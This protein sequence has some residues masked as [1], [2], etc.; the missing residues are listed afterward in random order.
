MLY[1]LN[2]DDIEKYEKLIQKNILEI[3][4]IENTFAQNSTS[5]EQI[6]RGT[7]TVQ[8]MSLLSQVATGDYIWVIYKD[9]LAIAKVLENTIDKDNLKIEIRTD[10]YE[11]NAQPEIEINVPTDGA[12][13]R[14]IDG[15]V[16]IETIALFND[17]KLN[18]SKNTNKS[19]IE[20]KKRELANI[21]SEIG[22]KE[23]QIKNEPKYNFGEMI[24]ELHPPKEEPKEE[25]EQ[26]EN[27]IALNDD[28][29]DFYMQLFNQQMVFYNQ[30]QKMTMDNFMNMQKMFLEMYMKKNK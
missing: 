29:M 23:I 19:L 22:K 7:Q 2:I 28:L 5:E 20:L 3:D 10:A 27:E 11:L 9:R 4:F 1:R 14:I 25:K 6:K 30:L 13:E 15:D 24:I 18:A 26:A 17:L 21:Q 8:L 12:L 16:L